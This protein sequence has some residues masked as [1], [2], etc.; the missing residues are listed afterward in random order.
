[1]LRIAVVGAG[2]VGLVS[3]VAFA[4][5]G[6]RVHVLDI[7]RPKVEAMARG[8]VPF[9]EP[10]LD[11]LLTFG[12]HA[13]SLSFHV[14]PHEAVA[15]ADV[16]FICVD[17][18]NGGNGA[19]DLRAIVGAARSVGK[20]VLPGSVVV[21]RSTA[22][23]GTSEYILSLVEEEAAGPVSVAVNPEFLAEGSAVRDF[24][25]PDRI[26]VGATDEA[27]FDRLIR[28]YDPILRRHLPE[29]VPAHVRRRAADAGGPV[30]L[31]AMD[32]ASAELTKYAANAFLAV[33]ISFINEIA[34]IA[35]ELG[36][37]VDRVAEAVGL[38]RRIGPGFLRAGIGWGGSCFP[39][40][41]LALQGMAETRG[42]A[43]RM[44]RAANEVNGHQQRW[45]IRQ[46]Q[47]HLRRL[48]GRRIGLLGLSFKPGTDDLRNAPSL[49]IA[50]EL[51]ELG[52]RVR[53]F[54]PVVHDL[55][56]GFRDCLELSANPTALAS[57]AE[58]LV[59]VTEWPEFT[60]LDLGEIRGVM[61][62]PLL[63]D[64]R[65]FLD[66]ELCREAGFAYVG[67][68]RGASISPALPVN[69][70]HSTGSSSRP[71]ALQQVP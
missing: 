11:R 12:L 50:A 34:A 37:D 70:S 13:G 4:A 23:V 43:P 30:P 5:L 59:L 8:D 7:D 42:L 14:D 18:P 68:G 56:D 54:D 6:H 35:D 48:V 63:L 10:N 21:N 51:T 57:D 44:L 2:H 46:L 24:F 65:N 53:A 66:A 41:V 55:P 3:A 29:A 33:K 15:G 27:A 20:H 47:A 17:T 67:V 39:K 26:V 36:A 22:P 64:G 49:D 25:V 16:V 71:A 38:D 28:A 62:F 31:V 19:V 69:P 58:A 60:A 40:D 32:P 9:V 1:M 52:A 45:V 61:R